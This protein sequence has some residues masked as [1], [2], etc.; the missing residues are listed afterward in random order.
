MFAIAL[1]DRHSRSLW[2]VRDRL[3]K[4]PLYYGRIGGTF[5][6]GSQPKSFFPPSRLAGRDR[7]R[8]PHRLHALRLCARAALDLQGPRQRPPGRVHRGAR[9]RGG[10]AAP[11]LGCA[12]QGRGGAGR[13]DGRPVRRGGGRALR[14]VAVRGGAAADDLGRAARR[15]PFRRRRQLGRRRPDAGERHGARQ[16]LQHRLRRERLRRIPARAR[17]WRSTWA[18]TITSSG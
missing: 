9:R 15:L 11:L 7:S 17:R 16:D 3:G 12:R 4:K 10:G 5:F 14:G 2:L 8:Q 13:A 6:F 18:P 1:W